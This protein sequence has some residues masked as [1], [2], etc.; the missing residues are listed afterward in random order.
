MSFTSGRP[1]PC[2]YHA[3]GHCARGATCK[4]SHLPA[5]SQDGDLHPSVIICEFYK[6]GRCHFGDQCQ[7]YHPRH[8]VRPP[9]AIPLTTRNQ[10]GTSAGTGPSSLSS[11]TPAAF[12]SCKFYLQGRCSKGLA[13][14]FLHPNTSD[15]RL[16][17][18]IQCGDN[19]GGPSLVC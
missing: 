1:P 4:F 3:R 9:S 7:F 13:C 11:P 12:G 15:H 16:V 5:R 8:V 18:E 6:Q 14:P 17:A 19:S 10:M 2:A